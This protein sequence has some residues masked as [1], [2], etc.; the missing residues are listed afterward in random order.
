MVV[1]D[2]IGLQHLG[3]QQQCAHHDNAHGHEIYEKYDTAMLAHVMTILLLCR[4]PGS[5]GFASTNSLPNFD[6]Q[7]DITMHV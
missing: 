5:S 4:T 2:P 6:I 7:S 1:F 3:S